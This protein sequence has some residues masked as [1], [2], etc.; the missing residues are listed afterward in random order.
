MKSFGGYKA[1]H[2]RNDP[3]GD[4]SSM[5]EKGWQRNFHYIGLK[6]VPVCFLHSEKNVLWNSKSD[7]IRFES[8]W[9]LTRELSDMPIG[10]GKTFAKHLSGQD[11][12]K[13]LRRFI[14]C[15]MVSGTRVRVLQ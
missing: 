12:R 8:I 15:S 9:A 11:V 6:A 4:W 3:L 1:L 14:C 2:S 5:C 7:V 10:E 13:R